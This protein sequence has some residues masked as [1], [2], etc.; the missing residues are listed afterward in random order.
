MKSNTFVDTEQ[1]NI[2]QLAQGGV[3]PLKVEELKPRTLEAEDLAR[4]TSILS[5]IGVDEFE[6]CFKDITPNKDDI[7]KSGMAL[8]FKMGNIILAN[9]KKAQD[10]IIH[11]LADLTGTKYEDI[12]HL[13]LGKFL[14]LLKKVIFDEDMIDFFSELFKS[15][16]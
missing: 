14:K 3:I 2:P 13:K 1:Q 16:E 6:G 15:Q 11:L 4:V 7:E 9:Y 8:A 12:A 10:D 5:K